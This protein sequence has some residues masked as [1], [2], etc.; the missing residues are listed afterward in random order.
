MAEPGVLWVG[1]L[2]DFQEETA[3]GPH[4]TDGKVTFH[5]LNREHF[6]LR[7]MVQI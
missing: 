2:K 5:A 1:V 3:H 6:I 7:R 4:E